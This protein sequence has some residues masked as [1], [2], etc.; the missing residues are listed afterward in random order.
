MLV[1]LNGSDNP[2]PA[3]REQ[4]YLDME[5]QVSW[6]KP[7]ISSATAKK[8]E[9]SGDSGVKMSGRYEYVSPNYWT[10]DTKAGGAYGVNTETSHGQAVPPVEGLKAVLRE[11]K[12][13]PMRE[14]WG[15][16]VGG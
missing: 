16:K 2:P 8:A 3:N 11:G 15:C 7:V 9:F 12:L 13:G 1:W 4:A 6:P 10:M 5:K 14:S